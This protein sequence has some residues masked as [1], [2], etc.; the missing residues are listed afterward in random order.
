M[1]AECDGPCSMSVD[2]ADDAACEPGAPDSSHGTETCESTGGGGAAADDALNLRQHVRR[3]IMKGDVHAAIDCI[4][5][6]YPEILDSAAPGYEVVRFHLATQQYIE[7]ISAGSIGEA[8]AFAQSTLAPMRHRLAAA[9]AA[10]A[11][12]CTSDAPAAAAATTPAAPPLGGTSPSEADLCNVVALVAY[13]KPAESPLAW[14][15]GPAQREH[16][17]DAANAA[18]LAAARGQPPQ[19]V[20]VSGL[21]RLLAQLASVRA[22]QLETNHNQ[23]EDFDLRQH[24]LPPVSNISLAGQQQQQQPMHH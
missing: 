5:G 14:L 15:L 18:V 20:C 22:T 6:T 12:A 13:E 11:S 24:L 9:A 4:R 7:L 2:A 1:G 23:G 17:A 16:V 19:S 10:T 3:A 8:I 21:E